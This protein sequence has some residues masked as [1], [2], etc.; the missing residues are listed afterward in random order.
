MRSWFE[1]QQVTLKY[2]QYVNLHL[3]IPQFPMSFLSMH[4]LGPCSEIE[5]GNQ[6]A[7][8][9]NCMLANYVFMVPIRTKTTEDVI[10][11]YLRMCIPHLREVNIS[12]VTENVNLPTSNLYG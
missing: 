6:Y 11:V 10:E 12:L 7:L 1:C 9:V 2:P 8:V 5:N 4:Q 3:P